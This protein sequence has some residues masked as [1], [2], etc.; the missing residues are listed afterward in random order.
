MCTPISTAAQ[1]FKESFILQNKKNHQLI[2]PTADLC[3]PN[4]MKYSIE[5]SPIYSTD[6]KKSF[7]TLPYLMRSASYYN[8]TF[9]YPLKTTAQMEL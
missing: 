2:P 9:Y 6:K 5:I 4:Y 8:H 1:I 7:C 3:M